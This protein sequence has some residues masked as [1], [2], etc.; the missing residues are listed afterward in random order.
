MS[1]NVLN[2]YH[3]F[4][5]LIIRLTYYYIINHLAFNRSAYIFINNVISY[6]NKTKYTKEKKV[7]IAQF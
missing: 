3:Y 6:I 5:F 1:F 7:F 2:F 4:L